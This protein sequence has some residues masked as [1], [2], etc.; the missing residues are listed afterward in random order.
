[1]EALKFKN[2]IIII[3][4]ISTLVSCTK[5]EEKMK[6]IPYGT[7]E[8]EKFVKNVPVSLDKAWKIQL[9]FIKKNTTDEFAYKIYEGNVRLF[10]IVDDY[11]V[12]SIGHLNNKMLEG[13]FLSGTWVNTKTGEVFEKDI[14]QKIKP[15]KG[16]AKE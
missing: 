4:L 15:Q 9:D 13:Y 8:F 7:T 5:G 2:Y 16:W 10:F 14:R 6:I 12:F 11:Y 1:M 3:L